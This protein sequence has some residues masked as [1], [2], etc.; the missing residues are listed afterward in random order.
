MKKGWLDDSDKQKFAYGGKIP[1]GDNLPKAV[2]D[3]YTWG[4]KEWKLNS[5]SIKIY[6]LLNQEFKEAD[7]GIINPLK[8]KPINS[9]SK[10]MEGYRYD[11]LM[12]E[13]NK[14]NPN[15]KLDK[16]IY[17]TEVDRL[18]NKT[19]MDLIPM[20]TTPHKIVPKFKSG[21]WLDNE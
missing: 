8:V 12:K 13:T 18:D 3:A 14:I 6:N 2:V 4:D 20:L 7:A 16:K 21:G 5:D 9:Y 15:I 1:P 11:Q 17:F 10:G 19:D